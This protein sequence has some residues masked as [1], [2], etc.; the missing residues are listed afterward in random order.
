M[1][2]KLKGGM[3]VTAF[4]LVALFIFA[5]KASA[6]DLYYGD[7]DLNGVIDAADA[8]LVQLCVSGVIACPANS[9][10]SGHDAAILASD[11]LAIQ[12]YMAFYRTDLPVVFPPVANA[13]DGIVGLPYV[14]VP[15]STSVP[16]TFD[17]YTT[18][19]HP[20]GYLTCAGIVVDFTCNGCP[21][22]TMVDT[23]AV[24][25]ATCQVTTT[26]YAGPTSGSGAITAEIVLRRPS[27]AV[28]DIITS[29]T[30]II[31]PPPPCPCGMWPGTPALIQSLP[32]NGPGNLPPD[33]VT[34]N[35]PVNAYLKFIYDQSLD[36]SGASASIGTLSLEETICGD[37][38]MVWTA[39]LDYET[40][41]NLIITGVVDCYESLA[42]SD[43]NLSLRTARQVTFQNVGQ[44]GEGFLDGMLIVRVV[45]DM[46]ETE[47]TEAVVRINTSITHDDPGWAKEDRAYTGGTITFM[48][49][50]VALNQP[51]TVSVMAPEYEYLTFTGLDAR[52]VVLGLRLRGEGIAARQQTDVIGDFDP[53]Q[54]DSIH[55]YS[56]REIGGI[57]NPI[58]MGLATFGFYRQNLS[59][60][61][62]AD[63]L[64]PKLVVMVP[65]CFCPIINPGNL[66]MP[67]MIMGRDDAPAASPAF[68]GKSFY[69]LRTDRTGDMYVAVSGGTA[70]FQ[71]I[72][73]FLRCMAIGIC[74]P[75]EF[76]AAFNMTGTH[77]DIQR[78]N[79]P[80]IGAGN[81]LTLVMGTNNITAPV[82]P[83][84][85]CSNFANTGRRTILDNYPFG[86]SHPGDLWEEP[87]FEFDR[88]VRVNMSNWPYDPDMLENY[89]NRRTCE[90]YNLNPAPCRIPTM[91]FAL[92]DMPDGT[93]VGVSLAFQ[94]LTQGG[95]GTNT[96]S[97]KLLGLPDVTAI[98]TDLGVFGI[99]PAV[100]TA[101]FDWEMRF[102]ALS[103]QGMV[104]VGTGG[105]P[106]G[107]CNVGPCYFVENSEWVKWIYGLNPV[108]PGV[109]GYNEQGNPASSP[110][111]DLVDRLF[112]VPELPGS[113]DGSPSDAH[114]NTDMVVMRL[115][116][117]VTD[118]ATCLE[119]SYQVEDYEGLTLVAV[120]IDNP[121]WRFYAPARLTA[122]PIKAHLP[123]VPTVAEINALGLTG[124]NYTYETES[125]TGVPDG[126]EL[127]W[128]LN[129]VNLPTNVTMDNIVIRDDMLFGVRHTSQ[130]HQR[131]IFQNQ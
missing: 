130:N 60:L 59:T 38:T 10:A 93:Q 91:Q 42:V 80:D 11:L 108:D 53:A 6:G 107:Q 27:G 122:G 74:D 105:M 5:P 25:D 63:I 61:K 115:M 98:E 97:S 79:V 77:C 116:D 70:S 92:L 49:T 7:A 82:D 86:W 84:T 131:F 125:Q 128:A 117:S 129:A 44:T 81:C 88:A 8:G 126:F 87:L 69:R 96:V 17:I 13:I 34:Q 102:N 26:I 104:D 2:S 52:E 113:D 50:T 21:P 101:A 4:F 71:N 110:V 33:S 100:A 41:Y 45:D 109:P 30:P 9:D 55:P 19:Y 68:A 120:P 99:E 39:T 118:L 46:E 14:Y 31:P 28:V 1:S 54:F 114:F 65:L 56:E 62:E 12:Q 43:I 47:L 111:N 48:S 24:A 29:E 124:A 73:D 57:P 78:I 40:D 58:R 90:D 66:L 36:I 95:P 37:D 127:E 89:S 123:P 18:I 121:I 15:I 85:G 32:R 106:H 22:G 83:L 103:D 72:G 67:D 75:A 3:G 35:I 64:A 16:V 94:N 119:P 112:E 23:P 20:R 76:V 51:I